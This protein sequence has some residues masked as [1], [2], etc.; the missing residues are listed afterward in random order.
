MLRARNLGWPER[1]EATMKKWILGGV[2]AAV[3]GVGS[4]ASAEEGEWALYDWPS[5]AAPVLVATSSGLIFL[6]EEGEPF[7]AYSWRRNSGD[8]DQ[9]VRLIDVDG[10]GQPNIVGSGRPTFVLQAS[11]EPVFN[12]EAGCQQ[13]L[14][15]RMTGARGNDVVCVRQREVRA[16]TGDG[17]FAWSVEP[18]RN[19]EFCRTGDVSGNGRDDVEC[20]YRGRDSY[21]RVGNDGAIL[22]ESGE[23]SLLEDSAR[24][25]RYFGAVGEG[26]WTGEER[27]DIDGDGQAT[28]SLHVEDGSLVIR[29]SGAEEPVATIEIGGTL[30]AAA[31]KD[32]DGEGALTVVALSDRGLYVI[33]EGGQ[34]VERYG[35]DASRYRRVPYADL[36]SVYARGFGESDED[37]RQAVRDLQDR[38]SQCY[39]QRLRSNAFAGSGRQMLQVTVDGEGSVSVQQTASQVGDRQVETC[40]RQ[41]LEGGGYP[42]ADEDTATINVNIMFTFRDEA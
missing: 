20:K 37:A 3:L 11:G 28:E 7:R 8:Q 36:I 38:I 10:D 27:F 9:A 4:V 14:L 30:Q 12:L 19:L 39:G 6:S 32:L 5:E 15:G 1:S 26:V 16:Y 29:K 25:F 21:L 35:V 2:V 31:V 40:A 34:E 22:E 17:Q 42:A 13:V 24:T 23:R 33:T 41:A 18:G